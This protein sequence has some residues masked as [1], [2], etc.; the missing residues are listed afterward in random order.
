MK[1]SNNEFLYLDLFYKIVIRDITE[2]SVHCQNGRSLKKLLP[3]VM[4]GCEYDDFSSV[5]ASCLKN[6]RKYKLETEMA[7]GF[8]TRLHAKLGEK[9]QLCGNPVGNCAENVTGNEVLKLLRH[10]NV[11]I[12]ALSELK[13][14]IPIRPRTFQYIPTCENC[15]K[16]FE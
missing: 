6:E 9:T 16:M 3:A 11:P 15:K 2:Y 1:E 4:I 14:T 12:P 7:V 13:F 10:N 5:G 8:S